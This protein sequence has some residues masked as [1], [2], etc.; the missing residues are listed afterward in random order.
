MPCTHSLSAN[1]PQPGWVSARRQLSPESQLCCSIR[2]NV[3]NVDDYRLSSRGDA[4][5]EF[6]QPASELSADHGERLSGGPGRCRIEEEMAIA[7]QDMLRAQQ[8]MLSA[9]KAAKP[10]RVARTAAPKAPAKRKATKDATSTD[11]APAP[12]QREATRK[13]IVVALLEREGGATLEEIMT[14]AS[15]CTSLE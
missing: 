7:E 9:T 8:E 13:A 10:G 14:Y 1:P 11:D 3:H 15:H 6:F 12:K 2:C 5:F 4:R